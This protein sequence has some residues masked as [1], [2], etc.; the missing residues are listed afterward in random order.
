MAEKV[1]TVVEFKP[2]TILVVDDKKETRN[3]IRLALERGNY[4]IIEAENGELAK[5]MLLKDVPDLVILDII[6]PGGDGYTLVEDLSIRE[7][8]KKVPIIIA[9]GKAKLREFFPSGKDSQI[10][11]FLEKPFSIDDLMNM[12]RE[13]IG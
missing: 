11:G 2:K 9:S 4:R 10:K 8:T 3:L 1:K 7:K 13:I 5:K 12:V 6:M